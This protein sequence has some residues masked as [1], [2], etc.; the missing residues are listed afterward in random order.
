M[1][2]RMLAWLAPE[3]LGDSQGSRTPEV[4]SPEMKQTPS[5]LERQGTPRAGSRVTVRETGQEREEHLTHDFLSCF[6]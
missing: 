5:C 2:P 1:V 4:S 3:R 6:R